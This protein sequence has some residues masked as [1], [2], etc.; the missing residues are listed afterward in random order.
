MV[1][2]NE[3]LDKRLLREFPK[4]VLIA[5]V[6]KIRIAELE[7]QIADLEKDEERLDLLQRHFGTL[8]FEGVEAERV[9]GGS[10]AVDYWK[11]DFGCLAKDIN[12]DSYIGAKA[13]SVRDAI[14]ATARK[15]VWL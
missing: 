7:N 5:R 3:E 12:T 10:I 6:R 14:A 4:Y 2:E 13:G 1:E 15:G 11:V 8:S 9:E